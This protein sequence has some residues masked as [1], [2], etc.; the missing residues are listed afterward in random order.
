MFKTIANMVAGAL[1]CAM[2]S[3]ALALTG[4][5]PSNGPGLP[6][7]V[8]LNGLANGQNYS[9]QSGFTAAGS[10]QATATA[11][12]AN[13]YLME[14]DTVAG[15]TGVNLPPCVPG[16]QEVIYNNGASTLT[17][18]PAVANNV[19]TSA[20]DTINNATSLSLTSHTST[21]PACIKAGVWTA[22]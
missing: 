19:L 4:T 18:Y 21:S 16:T 5:P 22:G 14:V 20:Q 9:Y 10:T 3:A 17:I 2:V 12:P 7:G 15:S 6:D 11:L 1:I 8:W 13:I